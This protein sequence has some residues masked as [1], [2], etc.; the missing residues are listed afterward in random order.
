MVLK[1][2]KRELRA[3]GILSPNKRRRGES[4]GDESPAA[5]DAVPQ[6]SAPAHAH[7]QHSTEIQRDYEVQAHADNRPEAQHLTVSNMRIGDKVQPNS[8]TETLASEQVNSNDG[9]RECSVCG[10]TFPLAYFPGL[11][12]CTHDPDVCRECFVE[13]LD[14]K[15][16]DIAIDDIKCPSSGC[17]TTIT[18]EAVHMHAPAEVF[19]R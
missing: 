10:E 15:M 3:L 13:W 7:T 12:G 18:H 8:V 6:V 19:Q 1:I 9:Q 5:A 14:H 16:K 4:P 17:K 11:Q 2:G